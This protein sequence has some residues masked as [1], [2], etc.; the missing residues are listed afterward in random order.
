VTAELPVAIVAAAAEGMHST[1][2]VATRVVGALGRRSEHHRDRAGSSEL[3]ISLCVAERD[4][5]A[6]IRAIQEGFHS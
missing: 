5:A 6:A 1:P 4:Q 2:G 3:N